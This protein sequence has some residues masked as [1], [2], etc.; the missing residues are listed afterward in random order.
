M[1]IEI[2]ISDKN[3]EQI[4]N[5]ISLLKG[6]KKVQEVPNKT[7]LKAM[8]ESDMIAEQIKLFQKKP[9]ENW[10]EAKRAILDV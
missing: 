9:Y 1:T 6:V 5:A 10:E 8:K 2:E 4:I 7:T 3:K